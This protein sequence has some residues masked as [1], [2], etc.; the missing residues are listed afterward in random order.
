MEEEGSE[1]DNVEQPNDVLR[2]AQEAARSQVRTWIRAVLRETALQ[3]VQCCLTVVS[4]HQH[5][6]NNQRSDGETQE[7][8]TVA[9][10]EVALDTVAQAQ[11]VCRRVAHK[12][13]VQLREAGHHAV[14]GW[15]DEIVEAEGGTLYQEERT[16]KDAAQTSGEESSE[17]VPAS[18]SADAAAA[19]TTT[20]KLRAE[21]D[22]SIT[23]ALPSPPEEDASASPSVTTCTVWAKLR[24]MG[25]RDILSAADDVPVVSQDSVLQDT[26]QRLDQLGAQNATYWP[27]NQWSIIQDAAAEI[28]N[29]LYSNVP[30]ER[31]QD[32]AAMLKQSQG[33]LSQSEG[34]YP[35]ALQLFLA[36][37]R[38]GK[39]Q[40]SSDNKPRVEK[41]ARRT[42]TTEAAA[43]FIETPR[44]PSQE[45]DHLRFSWKRDI[46]ADGVWSSEEKAQLDA[47]LHDNHT[48]NVSPPDEPSPPTSLLLGALLDLGRFTYFH[49][50]PADFDDGIAMLD[51]WTPKQR[52]RRQHEAI[53]MRLGDHTKV[54]DDDSKMAK[55]RM[56]RV[57]RTVD[58][59]RPEE[60][61]WLDL[62]L[63]HCLLERVD[64]E[65]GHR[66]LYAFGSL[67]VFLLDLDEAECCDSTMEGA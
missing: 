15:V 53:Q 35:E 49:Q 9:V 45:K 42:E 3:A 61:R 14:A 8:G 67:E 56:S 52:R 24:R 46:L 65:S 37:K 39:K 26:I 22:T 29:R 5:A 31:S 44:P 27:A 41:R 1:Q 4:Q 57:A 40:P 34:E 25:K 50:L 13:A 11:D 23:P 59:S 32:E 54:R 18:S 58:D 48:N 33:T 55:K 17:S 64:A 66:T 47:L 10:I 43:M 7:D 51:Q 20:E 16:P 28:P 38:K 36:R 21:S 63:G 12:W 30:S 19:A 60:R 2:V 62:D 6:N